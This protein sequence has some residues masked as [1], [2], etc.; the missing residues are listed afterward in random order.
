MLTARSITY[1]SPR[2]RNHCFQKN[3]LF[4][5][6]N[7]LSG[8]EPGL[9]SI[10]VSCSGAPSRPGPQDV[11]V[12]DETRGAV[13][14]GFC[15]S[16]LVWQTHPIKNA[17]VRER[18]WQRGRLEVLMCKEWGKE[19]E[20]VNAGIPLEKNTVRGGR[21]W[22]VECAR[23]IHSL[24]TRNPWVS[25]FH[26]KPLLSCLTVSPL[27]PYSCLL[28]VPYPPH[29]FRLKLLKRDWQNSWLS[30]KTA[31]PPWLRPLSPSCLGWGHDEHMLVMTLLILNLHLAVD[32]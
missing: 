15:H 2:L 14:G 12:L 25:G 30:V 20:W 3:I 22:A 10:P 11:F 27:S 31:P 32:Q 18:T 24:T 7:T 8:S 23:F 13:E 5:T 4:L 6:N 16:V 28:V 17:T 21:E 1:R 26:I 9:G 19:G 29:R